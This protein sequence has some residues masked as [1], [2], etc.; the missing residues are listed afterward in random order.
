MMIDSYHFD[1]T[2]MDAERETPVEDFTNTL[3]AAADAMASTI[4]GR[5]V[6]YATVCPGWSASNRYRRGLERGL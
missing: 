1:K 5:H 6:A 4:W 3:Y 2:P